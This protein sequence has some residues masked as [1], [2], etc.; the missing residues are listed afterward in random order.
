MFFPWLVK[1][2]PQNFL[3][4]I[5]QIKVLVCGAAWWPPANYNL[6]LPESLGRKQGE[7]VT[8]RHQTVSCPP[9]NRLTAV[10]GSASSPVTAL[11][12]NISLIAFRKRRMEKKIEKQISKEVVI[13]IERLCRKQHGSKRKRNTPIKKK[14]KGREVEN[15]IKWQQEY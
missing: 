8:C 5:D 6:G 15:L 1:I 12:K 14:E 10:A 7:P 2:C 13:E 11:K 9:C 4:S 3:P